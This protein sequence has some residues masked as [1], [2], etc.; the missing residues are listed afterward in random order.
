VTD[1]AT[2]R[3]FHPPAYPYDRLEPLREAASALDGGVVDLSVG[4]PTDPPSALVLAALS[5]AGDADGRVRGYPAS[6]GAGDLLDEGAG[7]GVF[8]GAAE[9]AF[10]AGF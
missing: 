7:F 9:V 3:G 10:D 8:L 4:T 2:E 5:S 1:A 6:I